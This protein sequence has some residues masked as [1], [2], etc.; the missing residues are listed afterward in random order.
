[1]TGLY[2]A[3]MNCYFISKEIE[4]QV[5]KINRLIPHVEKCKKEKDRVK[6]IAMIVTKTSYVSTLI[7][8]IQNEVYELKD[9]LIPSY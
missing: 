6:L 2:N 9:G 8:E 5:K 1:M 4:Q 3:T 7:M